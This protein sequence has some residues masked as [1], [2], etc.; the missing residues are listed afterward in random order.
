MSQTKKNV[1]YLDRLTLLTEDIPSVN[2][3]DMHIEID[4]SLGPI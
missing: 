3:V 2:W 4:A 1:Q